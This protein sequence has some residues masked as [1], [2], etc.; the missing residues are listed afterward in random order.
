MTSPEQMIEAAVKIQH[1]GVKLFPVEGII[2]GHCTC[3]RKVSECV[4]KSGKV[5]AGKHP[6]L[7]LGS[8]TRLSTDKP[9]TLLSYLRDVPGRNIAFHAGANNA[10]ITDFDGE[11]GS[12]AFEKLYSEHLD[13]FDTP[14]EQSGKGYHVLH[15]QPADPVAAFNTMYGEVR[16]GDMYRVTAPSNHYTG[17]EYRALKGHALYEKPLQDMPPAFLAYLNG[18]R[19][20]KPVNVERATIKPLASNSYDRIFSKYDLPDWLVRQLRVGP[21]EDDRSTALFRQA[22]YLISY[23]VED[24]DVY[25]L[26]EYSSNNKFCCRKD[27]S[28][29]LNATISEAKAAV[30]RKQRDRINGRKNALVALR[31]A[32]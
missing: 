29:R 1:N 21:V 25:Y 10:I 26:L 4:Q 16:S 6:I 32:F 11:D 14:I 22:C 7:K 30:S 19:K 12:A 9:E 5:Q 28:K 17:A 24:A 2:D 31:G 8:W 20:S 15:R 3:G 27:E 13:W 18:I 23:G